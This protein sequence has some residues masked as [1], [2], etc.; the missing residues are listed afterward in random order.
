MIN[1]GRE[2]SQK[3]KWILTSFLYIWI[4][5]IEFQHES[6]LRLE[7]LNSRQ[8]YLLGIFGNIWGHY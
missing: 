7:V 2:F 3:L 8:F 1:I 6:I 4:E 5:G